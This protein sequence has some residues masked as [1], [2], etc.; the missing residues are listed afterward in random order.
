MGLAAQHWATM[1]ERSFAPDPARVIF[2]TS[3]FSPK[4][5]PLSLPDL[6]ILNEIFKIGRGLCHARYTRE[7]DCAAGT[8]CRVWLV[9][10]TLMPN[11]RYHQCLYYFY[12]SLKYFS[13]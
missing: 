1:I 9:V 10:F 2:P 11:N 13:R 6:L 3:I 4:V 7:A 12:L 8:L 5:F